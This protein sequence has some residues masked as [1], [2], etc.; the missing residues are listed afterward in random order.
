MVNKYN[1]REIGDFIEQTFSGCKFVGLTSDGE[2]LMRFPEDGD[3]V[4]EAILKKML[5]DE[6][7]DL[8]RITTVVEPSI[9]QVKE[10]VDQ[11]NILLDEEEGAGK[12]SGLLDIEE[13]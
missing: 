8:S 9:P 2:V 1:A 7:P 10:M 13:F 12:Q 11:L 6:F 4:N 5:R 3:I